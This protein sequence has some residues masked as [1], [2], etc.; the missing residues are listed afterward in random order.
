MKQLFVN[1]ISAWADR[2]PRPH[3]SPDPNPSP[4]PWPTPD[5]GGDKPP[6]C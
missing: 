6:H 4:D 3:P 1:V 2:K 5:D